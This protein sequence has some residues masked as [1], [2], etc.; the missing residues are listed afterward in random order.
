MLH[1]VVH[2]MKAIELQRKNS[3]LL[4]LL[5]EKTEELE[6]MQ[7]NATVCAALFMS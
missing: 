5:G 6:A 7:V 1:Y 3:V 2:Y 4:D